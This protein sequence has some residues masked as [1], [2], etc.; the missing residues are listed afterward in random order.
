MFAF[1]EYPSVAN[2]FKEVFQQ[3]TSLNNFKT[4]LKPRIDELIKPEPYMNIKLNQF[5]QLI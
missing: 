3:A 5:I 1:R 2:N 4:L